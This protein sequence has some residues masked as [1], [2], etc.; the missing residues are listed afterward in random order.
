[1]EAES[2]HG[3]VEARPY[4]SHKVPACTACRKR[5]VRCAVDDPNLPCRYCRGRSLQ[6]DH[7]VDA[8]G[9]PAS[10]P[11]ARKRKKPESA[12]D[13]IDVVPAS[14]QGANCTETMAT[15]ENSSPIMV[16]PSIAEDVEV[17]ERHLA[18]HS[19]PGTAEARPYVRLSGAKG[20]SMVYRRVARRREG[21][22]QTATPG[23]VQ[24]EIIE[25]V[26]GALKLEVLQLYDSFSLTNWSMLMHLLQI[27]RQSQSMLPDH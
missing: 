25:N 24:L 16:S 20:E 1:M 5:K 3:A 27:F 2:N 14:L 21:L 19:Q 7:G 10:T 8:E 18:S 17:L 4:R 23:S 12:I 9:R 22:Q 6:C 15:M 13:G 26:I 11:R